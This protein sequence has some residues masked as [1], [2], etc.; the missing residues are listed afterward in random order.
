MGA[1]NN[2]PNEIIAEIFVQCLPLKSNHPNPKDAPLLLTHVCSF[3]RSL[4]QV[5]PRLWSSLRLEPHRASIL[6]TAAKRDRALRTVSVCIEQYRHWRSHTPMTHPFDLSIRAWNSSTIKLELTTDWH[7]LMHAIAQDSSSLRSLMVDVEDLRYCRPIWTLTRTSICMLEAIHIRYRPEGY[8][9]S[10]FEELAGIQTFAAAPRLRKVILEYNSDRR[11]DL[12]ALPWAQLTHLVLTFPMPPSQFYTLL[13]DCPKLEAL[14][15]NFGKR[16]DNDEK[17]NNTDIS[18][19]SLRKL[20][21]T[22]HFLDAE[23]TPSLFSSTDFPVLRSIVFRTAPTGYHFQWLPKSPARDHL[24][25]QLHNLHT[26]KLG[27]QQIRSTTLLELFE[28]APNIVKLALDSDIVDYPQL[29]AALTCVLSPVKQQRILTHLKDFELYVEVSLGVLRENV[30]GRTDTP[31]TADQFMSMVSSRSRS[32]LA[33][34]GEE[35]NLP[36]YLERVHLC[37]EDKDLIKSA[38]GLNVQELR[39]R[40]ESLQ[41]KENMIASFSLSKD[42]DRWLQLEIKSWDDF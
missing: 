36:A 18:S 26:L 6:D 13:H 35:P 9:V 29:L 23:P 28:T 3:W 30:H 39:E 32:F 21:I 22:F 31:F 7:S 11:G 8:R 33:S 15:F 2:L 1:F 34:Q 16:N 40:L 20:D 19:K 5:T 4:A 12:L 41:A 17:I 24:F 37:I 27:F 25:S 42:K 14:A 38:E 10:I